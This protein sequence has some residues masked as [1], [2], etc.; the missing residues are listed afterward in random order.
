M[1]KQE[2]YACPVCNG[3]DNFL[4]NCP[5]CGAPLADFGRIFDFFA[6]YSP[7]RPIDDLKM[8]D[9]WFDLATH[10]CPHQVYC[11]QCGYQDVHMI[12]EMLI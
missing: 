8:T 10:K 2:S 12:G 9:G 11:P 6:D 3:F 1:N 4:A 7:Y 5:D